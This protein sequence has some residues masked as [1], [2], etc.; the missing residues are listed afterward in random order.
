M[1]LSRIAVMDNYLGPTSIEVRL[2]FV[3]SEQCQERFL[4]SAEMLCGVSSE[5]TARAFEGLA[6]KIRDIEKVCP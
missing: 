1:K 3:K 4:V 6:H 2:E 5:M